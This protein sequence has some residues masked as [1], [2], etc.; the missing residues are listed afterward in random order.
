MSS[1]VGQFTAVDDT[2]DTSWFIDFMDTTN[3]QPEYAR[4]RS[5]LITALG[6]LSGR[7]VLDV[8]CGTGDD[9]REVAE[10]VGPTGRVVGADLS[11]AMLA[12][13]RRR[14]GPVEFVPADVHALPFPDASF[15]A[16]RVKLVRLHSPDID[17]ADDELVRVLRPGG[18]LAAFDFD[19]ETFT[20]DHPDQKA[21]RAVLNHW[22][23]H[24]HREGWCGRQTRRRL[25]A[26]GLTDVTV[27][28][29]TVQTTYDLF[30][31]V[32]NGP[33]AEAVALGVID[34]TAE[35]FYAPL[36]EAHEKGAFFATL[37]GYVL[38]ATR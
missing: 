20:L 29:H 19:V 5:S 31:A 33:L 10:L 38:G 27:A 3:A 6:P 12:E 1:S 26:R 24:H 22:V 23:D 16:V 30:R 7:T 17:G 36:A 13:A 37:T 28:P 2:A 15:D 21:T 14:G 35:E 9:T 25:L 11:E 8:G 32:I 18:R 4:I 34:M